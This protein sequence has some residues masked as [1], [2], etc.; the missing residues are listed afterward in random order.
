MGMVTLVLPKASFSLVTWPT[1]RELS[2]FSSS[3]ASRVIW[4]NC[5]RPVLVTVAL[6]SVTLTLS[7]PG[8]GATR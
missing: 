7:M 8:R 5:S 3:T 2:G 1:M 4:E 6:P